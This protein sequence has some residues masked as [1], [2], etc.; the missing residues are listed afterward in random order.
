M[1]SQLNNPFPEF[2]KQCSTRFWSYVAP[3]PRGVQLTIG[4]AILVALWLIG[5]YPF[6]KHI[7]PNSSSENPWDRVG[8][9]RVHA[10]SIGS[11]EALS[12]HF[13]ATPISDVPDIR[14]FI[15]NCREEK[16]TTYKLI[17]EGRDN[18][19]V[20]GPFDLNLIAA[21]GQSSPGLF[22]QYRLLVI[23]AN[24]TLGDSLQPLR[25]R[26]DLGYSLRGIQL[27][28]SQ[29][30]LML[31]ICSGDPDVSVSPEVAR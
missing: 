26:N 9:R 29:H 1:P 24:G 22:L 14:E 12:A 19:D 25:D 23:T 18:L 3:W 8:L 30:R 10:T 6:W 5:S 20:V 2:L 16:G 15:V 28:D 4:A 21:S 11:A 7:L 17:L 13:P 31:L 27:D